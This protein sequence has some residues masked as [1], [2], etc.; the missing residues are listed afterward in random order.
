MSDDKERAIQMALDPH[1]K[2]PIDFGTC[3]SQAAR[4]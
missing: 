1:C 4:D 3:L 2:P